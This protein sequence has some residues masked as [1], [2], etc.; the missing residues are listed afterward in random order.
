MAEERKVSLSFEVDGSGVKPGLDTIEAQV[1]GMA[2]RVGKA[3]E[4]ASKGIAS[5][6][7]GG[8]QA[9]GK[10]DSATRSIIGS[11]QRTTAAQKAGEK[12]SASYYEA[13]ANQRGVSTDILKPYL[14]QL[15]QAEAAQKVAVGGLG[16]MEMSANATSAALRNVPAQFTDIAVSLQSGQKPLTVLLQQGGQLKDMF[17]GIGPAVKALGGYVLGLINP[18]TLAAAGAGALYLAMEQTRKESFALEV[19]LM[20]G[21]KTLGATA[22]QLSEIASALQSG[23]FTR[24]T[25]AA[26]LGAVA[27]SGAVARDA[28]QDFTKVA[29]DMD[30][31]VGTAVAETVKV[32]SKLADEPAKASQELNKELHYLTATQYEHIKALEEQGRKTDAARIAQQAYADA[33]RPAIEAYKANLGPLDA[34]L[35]YWTRKAKGMWDALRG[36]GETGESRIADLKAKL[37]DLNGPSPFKNAGLMDSI[38]GAFNP[39]GQRAKMVSALQEQLAYLERVTQA[40]KDNAKFEGERQRTQEA[41]IAAFAAVSSV[42]EKAVPKQQQMNKALEEYR[43]NI[44]KIRA[45]NPESALLDAKKIASGEKAI[46]DQFAEKKSS[47]GGG[48]SASTGQS[49]VASIRARVIETQR[50]ITA[51][52]EQGLEG[53][54]LNEGEKLS[55]KI[56]EELTGKLSGVARANKQIALV[57]AERLASLQK[58]AAAEEKQLKIAE[59]NERAYG[60]QIESMVKAAESTDKQAQAQERANDT[61]GQGK[62]AIEAM[63]LAQQ[64]SKL[65]TLQNLG[66]AGDYTE[67]LELQIE[68][69]KRYVKAMQEG[70]YKTQ[71]KRTDELVRSANEVAKL[72]QEEARLTGLSA[73]ERAKVVAQRQIE[74]KYAKELDLLNKTGL[75]SDAKD[76]ERAKLQ[77][78]QQVEIAAS[79]NKL[80]QEDW[81]ATVKQYDDIFRTGFADMLNNG[82]DGWKSFTKS[83]ATT[84]KTAVADQLYKSFAQPFVVKI[85]ASLLGITG[86]GAAMAGGGGGGAAQNISNLSSLAG[87]G[88]QALWGS[89]VGASA[90]SLGYAN[91]VGAVGGDAIGAL[92]AGNGAWA[93][94]AVEASAAAGSAASAA[95]STASAASSF[96]SAIAAAGPW[97][98]AAIALYSI[99]KSFDDS[100]TYHMGAGAVYNGKDGLKGG[101]DLYGQAAFGM[102]AKGEY[103]AA[104]Q[105]NVDSIAQG[106]GVAL[107]GVAVSFGQTAGYEIATAFADDSSKDGAWGSLRISKDG[108]DLLNWEDTRK[109]KWAPKEFSDGEG[110]Y[111]EYLAAVAKDTRQVLLDMDLPSWADTMLNS[112]GE[113]ASMDQLAGTIAQIGQIQTAFV[114]LGT[115]I[116]GFAGMADK[117]FEA[118][119]KASGGFANLQQS[120]SSY[121][122]NY[123]TEAE[124]MGKATEQLAAE[125]AKSGVALPESKEAYRALV[126]QQLAAG[127]GGAALAAKLLQL[128][129]AFAQ[130][131][132]YAEQAAQ[133]AIAAAKEAAGNQ[134]DSLYRSLQAAISME[135]AQL[136][137]QRSLAQESVSMVA[138]VFRMV[139]DNARD[140]YGEVQQTAAMQAAQGSAFIDKALAAARS[141]GALPDSG[142]LGTA[143]GAARGGLQAENFASQ[144][145][146]EFQK[147]VLAGKLTELGDISE[148][149]LSTAEL[150]LKAAELQVKRLD[151]TLDYWRQQIDIANGNVD[152][153][154]S[155]ADAIAALQK[156][157]FPEKPAAG[158]SASSPFAIGGGTGS[159]AGTATNA[160]KESAKAWEDGQIRSLVGGIY[161]GSTDFSDPAALAQISS[162]ANLQHWT[163]A[164]MDA[165]LGLPEGTVKDMMLGAGFDWWKGPK[166]AVGTNYVPRDQL[167]MVHEGEAIIPKAY[168]PAAGGGGG[169]S[170]EM[171]AELRA[172]RAELA[173]LKNLQAEGNKAASDTHSLLDRVTAGGNAMATEAMN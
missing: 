128:G 136:D 147:L 20:K 89:S 28:L 87:A 13:L 171:V 127:E 143:I 51:M 35:D 146:L 94:V 6:G 172:L 9:A 133:D 138:S 173:Q 23:G 91:A 142:A 47:A 83:L 111:K 31:Y 7:D 59:A 116:D 144:S 104:A 99:I 18:F 170:A 163:G 5:I 55:L 49:E 54:K 168:N 118:L 92:I 148:V 81:D 132:D 117:T 74:L 32:F 69:Q 113:A 65:A 19:A 50:Y 161:S 76:T 57:E 16:K 71:S 162:L 62:A 26:A 98:A 158:K 80:M 108:S 150:T 40:A 41:G 105:A 100:G 124:R 79:A 60:A 86:G 27:A 140:L 121:Y 135:R 1:D 43:A 166:Y 106:L 84:F 77:A 56:R 154:L 96:G 63:T 2:K 67:A 48:A 11:I 159:S 141:S 46:R 21:G 107:D 29:L 157:M 3:G 88:A 145:E 30:R 34:T 53:A 131:A 64:Q 75:S 125:L 44:E 122:E 160:M 164:Q 10:V 153:T 155:V 85:V 61:F 90:A 42:Q 167:A 149:Q 70:E 38:A 22:G 123:Y 130:V 39:S 165:A 101:A 139:R 129:G 119:M 33:V 8:G 115:T 66:L 14:D 134:R 58:T 95:A 73:L 25:A 36:A 137:I 17:G 97:I 78:A 45:A 102:G 103:N 151:Q 37:A 82:K 110:G 24:G 152:A 12:G 109:S 15:R 114:M 156:A 112:I 68:A 93:G 72:Y 52:Q 4:G 120:L 126:E 169:S